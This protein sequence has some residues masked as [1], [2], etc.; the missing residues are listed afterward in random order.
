MEKG[1]DWE[2]VGGLSQ[3]GVESEGSS[4]LL[5][6]RLHWREAAVFPAGLVIRLSG[7][8]FDDCSSRGSRISRGSTCRRGSEL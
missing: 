1:E 8:Q 4:E 2:R 3:G 5:E 7:W 6:I